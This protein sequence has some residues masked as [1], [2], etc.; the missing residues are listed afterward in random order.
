[1]SE[2]FKVKVDNSN[3]FEISKSDITNL[4]AVST[5]MKYHILKNNSSYKAEV[6][7]SIFLKKEYTVRVNSNTYE[8]K[9]KN[10]LDQL[11]SSMGFSIGTNKQID[12]IKAPMPGL[13]LDV[14]VEVGQEVKE[15]DALLI[16]EAMKME[17]VIVSQRKGIIKTVA[18]TKGEAVDK[19]HLLIEFE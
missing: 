8:V 11:I 9:I 16:L 18:I 2:K 12:T 1:M 14:L 4:D 10:T 15:D 6:V 19:N 7:N 17:N 5:K 3:E 13:I